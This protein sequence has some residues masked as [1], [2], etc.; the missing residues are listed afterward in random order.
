M[1]KQIAQ[2][3]L[4][5]DIVSRFP[6]GASIEEI[7]I[8]LDPPPSRRGL[9]YRLAAL[10]KKGSL[11]AQGKTR[12]KRYRLPAKET[13][14]I[15][16]KTNL[17][18]SPT[19]ES[20][21]LEVTRPIQERQHVSYNREF[22]DQYRPNITFYLP[23]I[24]R[25]RLFEL[26]K[27]DGDRPAGTYARQIFNRLLIDLSWNSSRLEGNTYSLLETENLI[28]LGQIA[29]GKNPK[30]TQMIL[31]HKAAI[32]FLIEAEVQIDRYSILSLHALLSDDLLHDQACGSLR[33]IPV[34][35]GG[36]VYLPLGVPQLIR[37]CFEQ[38]LD[39]ARVIKDPFEQAFFLMVHLPYLQ[40]FEDVNKR[41]SRLAANMPLIKANLRPLSFIDVP[42]LTYINGLIGVY[43]LNRI[44]LLRDVFVWAYER[45]CS[46]Y[47]ATRKSL[48][49]PD[50][51]RVR[52]RN[53]RKET[54]ASIVRAKLNKRAALEFIQRRAK[55]F[56]PLQDQQR[57][58]EVIETEIT[59]LHDG[60]CARYGL[61][62]SEFE[63]W[64]KG[65]R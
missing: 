28:E 47:A 52:Y 36:S 3:Q 45:S 65:W 22:L 48:G 21:Q 41:V 26:G 27:T 18:L 46:H 7:L 42:E 34:A 32:E 51:F 60:N 64:H 8:G 30:E 25:E 23:E 44:E 10:V 40:P 11:V 4:I 53:L 61:T 55:E 13:Q 14:V 54:V 20:I 29:Q 35:I 57:L 50:P 56:V 2:A 59:G 58:T 12:G 37:E 33:S 39:T 38:I 31:N 9:Q 24:V 17:Q 15:S 6:N 49:E 43:E 5:L 19:A 62:L 1:P 16:I 63:Q